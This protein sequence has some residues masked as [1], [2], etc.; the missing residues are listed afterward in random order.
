MAKPSG[1]IAAKYHGDKAGL[2]ILRTMALCPRPAV[3][4]ARKA[5]T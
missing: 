2:P 1:L 5:E 3:A 4:N